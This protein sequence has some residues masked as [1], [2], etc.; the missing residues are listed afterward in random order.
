MK[1]MGQKGNFQ[2]KPDQSVFLR[3]V[4]GDKYLVSLV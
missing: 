1:L 4:Q 2:N 3:T